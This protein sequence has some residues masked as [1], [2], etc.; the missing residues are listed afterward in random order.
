MFSQ[1]RRIQDFNTYGGECIDE[2]GKFADTWHD[3]DAGHFIA[4]GGGGFGLLFHPKNVNGQLKGCNNPVFS[5]NSPHGYARG[6]DKRYGAGTANELYELYCDAHF[7]GKT[8]KEWS[9]KEYHER[10]LAIQEELR[11]L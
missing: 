4:A 11:Q 1:L 2:C 9:Q 7:K 5:P 8:T 3:F 6:L 10:I